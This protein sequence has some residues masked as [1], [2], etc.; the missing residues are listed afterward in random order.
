LTSGAGSQW[1]AKVVEA[2]ISII[3]DIM[4]IRYGYRAT[5]RAPRQSP[6]LAPTCQ[7]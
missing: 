2:F 4:A 7:S 3:D 5:E 1:D 6:A